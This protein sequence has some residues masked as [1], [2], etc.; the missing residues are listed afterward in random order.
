M[1]NII[2]NIISILLMSSH[3]AIGLF[4]LYPM[5]CFYLSWIDQH[6]HVVGFRVALGAFALIAVSFTTSLLFLF[7]DLKFTGNN[8]A[9]LYNSVI[10]V[11]IYTLIRVVDIK[12]KINGKTL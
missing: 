2:I 3:L 11:I 12:I 5:M 6:P 1:I 8:I 7:C 10:T 4:L 9:L